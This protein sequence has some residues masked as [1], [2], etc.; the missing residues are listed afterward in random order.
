MKRAQQNNMIQ[1]QSIAPGFGPDQNRQGQS[2]SAAQNVRKS[3]P[4]SSKK[5][6]AHAANIIDLNDINLRLSENLA[7]VEKSMKRSNLLAED[8]D[9]ESQ[10]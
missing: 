10:M 7:L 1:R 2:N 8:D 3:M 6:Q 9:G 4:A 5:G